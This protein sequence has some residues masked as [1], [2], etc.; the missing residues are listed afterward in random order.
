ME[1]EG[2]RGAWRGM[3][4]VPKKPGKEVSMQSM[5][6]RYSKVSGLTESGDAARK[7]IGE[8]YR[9]KPD[10]LRGFSINDLMSVA[11]APRIINIDNMRTR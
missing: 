2:Q 3:W 4:S 9:D 5:L 6:D 7:L 10:Q 11:R 1:L 8:Y